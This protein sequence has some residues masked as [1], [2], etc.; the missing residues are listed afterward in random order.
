MCQS[1]R[2]GD[3]VNGYNIYVWVLE[4][5]TEKI[6]ANTTE[7]IYSDLKTHKKTSFYMDIFF[8]T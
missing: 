7:S 1:F 8:L 6:P 3:I 4:S 2:I 5:G